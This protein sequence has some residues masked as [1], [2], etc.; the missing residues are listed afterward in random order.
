MTFLL[1]NKQILI[2]VMQSI[3]FLVMGKSADWV[4]LE[5]DDFRRT[6]GYELRRL[7][8]S[9][10]MSQEQFA[11]YCGISRAYYGR[12]ERGEHSMT[13]DM[14]F[15]I[16]SALGIEIFDIFKNIYL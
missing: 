6:L 3:I 15:R 4:V 1:E 11:E 10:E 7:R 12:I 8:E 9:R 13:I 14:C 5:T 16:A 2:S